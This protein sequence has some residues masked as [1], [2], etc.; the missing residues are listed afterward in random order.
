MTALFALAQFAAAAPI[1][2]SQESSPGAGD[3]DSNIL[4]YILPFEAASQTP[5]EIYAYNG[6]SYG[7]TIHPWVDNTQQTFFVNTSQG[8]SL[9]HVIDGIYGGFSG[10]AS[11]FFEVF[12][13]VVAVQVFDDLGEIFAGAGGTTVTGEFVFNNCCTDGVVFGAL[14]GPAWAV[15]ASNTVS[16]VALRDGWHVA[17]ANQTFSVS[18]ETGRRVRFDV[19][20][21]PGSAALLGGG[22]LALA[23]TVRRRRNPS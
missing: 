12:N 17:G 9:F 22:I 23:W 18:D 8:L 7:G 10:S 19:V 14:D 1:R 11:L 3:F 21:E 6:F 5:A 20:P 15:H 16:P 4:G 2:V 13:D